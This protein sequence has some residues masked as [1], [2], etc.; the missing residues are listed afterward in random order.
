MHYQPNAV[1]MTQA[2]ESFRDL[3][4][5][6]RRWHIGLFQSM[7]KH[8]RIMFN[9]KFGFVSFFSYLYYLLY[10][11][12]SPFIEVFGLVAILVAFHIDALNLNYMIIFFIMYAIYGTVITLSAFS[13]HIYTQ[14]FRISLWDMI[15]A[16]FF[17]V[18]EFILFRYILV[19]V[20]IIAFLRYGKNKATWGQIKRV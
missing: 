7:I 17:C 3:R 19:I 12:F 9:L 1:C 5:Q 11:L 8:R 16:L 4:T 10:E 14:R 13:Q 2:P 18:I 6:R 20:R 15:K